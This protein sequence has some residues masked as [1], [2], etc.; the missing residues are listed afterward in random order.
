MVQSVTPV[1]VKLKEKVESPLGESSILE[2]KTTSPTSQPETTSSL[3]RHLADISLEV[4]TEEQ[5]KAAASLLVEQDAF[6][7]DDDD[8][9]SIPDLE[10]N[11]D[12]KDTTPVQ[13]NYAAV[14]RPLYPEVKSYIE[15]LLNCKFIKSQHPHTA[16][17]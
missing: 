11:I 9:G 14:P 4:L 15:D 1:E 8:F 13:K 12:R 3:P 5:K 10:L 16:H 7:K 2:A 6:A 17:L